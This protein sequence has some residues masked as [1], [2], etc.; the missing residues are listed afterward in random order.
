[1]SKK[2]T[3]EG[4]YTIIH[5]DCLEILKTMPDN[6]VDSVVTDPPYGISFMSKKWDYD[7]PNIDVWVEVLR[8]LKP[9]GHLLCFGGTR[10]FHRVAV[11]I[12]DAGFKIRDTIMWVYGSGFPKS[13]DVSKAIDKA[14]GVERKDGT[15]D[16]VRAAKLVNQ[17]NQ[18]TTSSGW[19]M[20]KRKITVDKPVTLEAKQW[21]GWGTALKPAWEPIILARKHFT[22][23]IAENVLKYGTGALNIDGCRI[24]LQETGEDSRLGGKGDWST[25][26]AAKNVYNGGYDGKRI[27][28]SKLGRFPANLIHDCSDE[29]VRLFPKNAG[30][31][32]PV[33]KGYSGK[34]KGIYGDYASKGDDG[35]SFLND[36]GSAARFF[37]CAKIS[38]RDREE[39][40]YD[41]LTK[42]CQEQ[43]CRDNESIHLNP[44]AG[45]GRLSSLHNHHPTVKP[46]NL[47][48]Y[49]CKLITPPNGIVLDP[50][51]GSGSTGKAAI[52]EGFR[53]IGIEIDEQ[54]IEIARKRI[55][56]VD[57]KPNPFIDGEE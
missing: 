10:T 41:L 29:V 9:G 13:A 12:E 28:S 35:A 2:E 1:M 46:T 45:A 18:Y 20:G 33:M 50:Y 36:S 27:S 22:T 6:S 55:E 30:A 42:K 54:Y 5:G 57:I 26:K 19:S 47:M 17:Q 34:S 51:M 49:L 37:Y 21:E 31:V 16:T 7:I 52:L 56:Y 14:A 38:K 11:S 24:P 53:F 44:R 4:Q 39:G 43:G 40:C 23:T 3:N 48:K 8:V 32:A 15:I 25:D